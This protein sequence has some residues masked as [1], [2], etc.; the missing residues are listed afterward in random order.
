[1]ATMRVGTKSLPSA[2]IFTRDV[3]KIGFGR[4]WQCLRRQLSPVEIS[5][6]GPHSFSFGNERSGRDGI[7]T[8]FPRAGDTRSLLHSESEDG[9]CEE[10][11]NVYGF[12]RPFRHSKRTPRR[13]IYFR[14]DLFIVKLR[15]IIIYR[16]FSPRYKHASPQKTDPVRRQSLPRTRQM[17]GS[18]ALF[19]PPPWNYVLLKKNYSPHYTR[20]RVDQSFSIVIKSRI[21][22]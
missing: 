5:L 14:A 11:E 9:V 22:V 8:M 16:R 13:V 3:W 10:N 7:T 4:F 17:Y 20:C 19:P 1:M 2:I 12:P 6:F 15:H 21:V 18:T